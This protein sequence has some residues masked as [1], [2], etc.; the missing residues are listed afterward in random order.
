MSRKKGLT[1][2]L[3][4]QNAELLKAKTDALGAVLAAHRSLSPAAIK[5]RSIV[6]ALSKS[7]SCLVTQSRADEK[8]SWC[9][10][11]GRK[12]F[13]VD[14]RPCSGCAHFCS[15]LNGSVCRRHL[16]RV[17]PDMLVTFKLSEGTCWTAP[18][19]CQ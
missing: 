4:Y 15:G 17:V 2:H 16:M 9:I 7:C 11:C 5:P 12:V 6:G 14:T 18:E 3:D 8:G 10:Q 19:V 1:A 13:E